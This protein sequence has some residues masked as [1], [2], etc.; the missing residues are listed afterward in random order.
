MKSAMRTKPECRNDTDCVLAFTR[1]ELLAVVAI[2]AL[3]LAV[4]LPALANNRP[5]SH[6]IICANNLRQIGVA[7]Q[8][9]GNDHGDLPPHQL[10]VAEGGTRRHPLA[11]NTWLHFSW[12]SNELANARLLFCP[13]D[14][15]RP[16]RDFSSDPTGGYVH[17][18][19]ANQATSYFL[20]HHYN[21]APLPHRPLAGDRNLR[22]EGF[23]SDS[24][25]NVAAFT[26]VNPVSQT[27]GWTNGLH[28]TVGNLLYADGQVEQADNRRLREAVEGGNDRITPV[29]ARMRFCVPR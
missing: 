24:F 18:N 20:T 15:G 1:A 14:T 13:S 28:D 12:L 25:Y 5:R 10:L 2:T 21:Y 9:W 8:V 17:P 27:F 19:F 29:L 16:A 11:A 7:M 26:F 23:T 22:M 6:R 4:A 3:L